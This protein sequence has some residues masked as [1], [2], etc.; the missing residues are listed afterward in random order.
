MELSREQHE[1]NYNLAVEQNNQAEAERIR[2]QMEAEEYAEA[3]A[4]AAEIAAIWRGQQKVADEW[5]EAVN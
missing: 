2:L 5:A 4:K 1:D 3:D